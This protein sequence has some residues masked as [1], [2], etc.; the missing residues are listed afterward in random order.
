MRINYLLYLKAQMQ[1]MAEEDCEF[2][3]ARLV[4]EK[5]QFYNGEALKEFSVIRILSIKLQENGEIK[6]LDSLDNIV[7]ATEAHIA[8]LKGV[9]KQMELKNREEQELHDSKDP[10]DAKPGFHGFRGI[11]TSKLEGATEKDKKKLASLTVKLLKSPGS[12]VAGRRP[13]KKNRRES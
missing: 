6:Y 5:L 13:T 10:I 11:R 8:K 3:R 12:S 2:Y 7:V 4:L 9:A 1:L